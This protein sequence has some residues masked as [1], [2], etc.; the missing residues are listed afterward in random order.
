MDKDKR[1]KRA[2]L[3]ALIVTAVVV[4]C[5][6]TP[7]LVILLGIIGLSALTPYLDYVLSSALLVLVILTIVSYRRWKSCCGKE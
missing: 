1:Y 7:V 3:A 4:V 2:F 5:C 6:F